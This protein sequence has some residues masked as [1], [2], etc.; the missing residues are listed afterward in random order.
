M[1]AGL[2][3]FF[4]TGP[5]AYD[6]AFAFWRPVTVFFVWATAMCW[7]LLRAVRTPRPATA[8]S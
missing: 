7:A 6:G 3:Y 4:K 1:P 2:I 8:N 5:F